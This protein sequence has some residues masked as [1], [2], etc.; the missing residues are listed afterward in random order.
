MPGPT[1]F[2]GNALG[3]ALTTNKVP[4]HILD[5]RVRQ[6]L[7]L[8]N[9]CAASKI[10]KIVTEKEIDTPETSAL[11]REIAADS[12]VLLKNTKQVLPLSK[13]KPVGSFLYN[14]QCSQS[15]C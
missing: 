12:I 5:D 8:V 6:M 2:R 1:R 7:R 11:L 15:K 13:S 4:K 9:R 10:P 14:I 3:H